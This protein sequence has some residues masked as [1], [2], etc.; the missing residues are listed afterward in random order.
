[1]NATIIG[2]FDV[3]AKNA[4]PQFQNI[5]WWYDFFSGDSLYID[6][7]DTTISLLPGEFHIFTD[8]RLAK[9]DED[10][11]TSLNTRPLNKPEEF[12]LYQNY[13]NPFNPNTTIKYAVGAIRESPLQNID[14]SIYNIL[15]QKITTLVKKKQQPGTYSVEW[16]ASHYSSGIYY[17]CLKTDKDYQTKKMVLIK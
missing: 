2:N 1:M 7:T 17:Y 5:G 16:D 8:K 12:E 13:P 9:P 15:G 3:I 14:L 10:L 6:N 11:L 4:Q